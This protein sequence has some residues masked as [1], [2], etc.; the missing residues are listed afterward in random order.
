MVVVSAILLDSFG[1]AGPVVQQQDLALIKGVPTS[2]IS[3][4]TCLV[5]VS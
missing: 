5:M 1:A 3:S 4:R 2:E